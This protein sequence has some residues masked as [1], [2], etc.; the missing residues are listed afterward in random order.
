MTIPLEQ[1][2]NGVPG[3]KY[4]TST[5][6]N[7]GSSSI[8]VT[9]DVTR[10]VD[11]ASVDVQNRVNQALG[12]LPNAVK[13]TGIII[14]KQTSG[15]VFGAGVYS[16]NGTV[17]Q[18]VPEQ[19]SGCLCARRTEARERRGRRAN[20]WRAQIRHARVAGSSA[21]CATWIDRHDG[22]CGAERT[23]RPGGRGATGPA[24]RQSEPELSDQRACNWPAFRAERVRRYYFEDRD[25]RDSGANQ[26]RGPRG[27]GRRR[28]QLP[29]ALQRP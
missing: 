29:A 15:F 19:L 2:I 24:A 5:S 21:A 11:L 18:P 20:L 1:A 23:K 3:M 7:D 28:L 25:R 12:R 22:S 6:G 26:R 10:D 8:T 27:I 4:I 16:E 17:R 13:N 9:F 14:T